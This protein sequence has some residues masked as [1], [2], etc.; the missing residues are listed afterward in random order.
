EEGARVVVGDI[1]VENADRVARQIGEAGGQAISVQFDISDDASV[2]ALIAA[3][4]ETYGG[5]D[6]LHA[7][8]A[9]LSIVFQD[10]DALTVPLEIFDRTIAVN[11]RGHLLCTRHAL[12]ALLKRGGGAIVYTS[13][14]AAFLGEQEQVSYSVGKS[15]LNALMRNVASRWG[16]QGIRANALAPG[17]VLTEMAAY[18]PEEIKR[19]YLERTRSPRLGTPADIAALVAF[20][21]SDDGA[22]INGQVLSIDG[23]LLLR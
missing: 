4:V 13:S 14:A 2:A 19:A 9:D 8:A 20:L 23:G 3:A 18:L 17:V 11:L 5:L 12:P 10:L 6:L 7:N 22:W 1:N 15:G 16:K 21:A